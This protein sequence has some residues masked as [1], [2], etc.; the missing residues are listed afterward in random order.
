METSEEKYSRALADLTENYTAFH[1][2]GAAA[3]CPGLEKT[4][5]LSARLGNPHCKYR[6]IHVGGTNGKGS[7]AHTIAAVLQSAGM[8][9]G[10][11][12]S[13]HILDFR[14]RIRVN[15]KMIRKDFVSEF[16]TKLGTIKGEFQPSYFEAVTLMAFD[17]FAAEKIDV[18]VIEVGLGGRLDSTNIITPDLSV[19]TNI[20][21]DHTAILGDTAEAIAAEKAGIIKP[22][23]P[24]VIGAA[25]PSVFE[26]FREKAASCDA[27]IFLASECGIYTSAT[28]HDGFIEYEGTP[29]GLVRGELTGDCQKENAATIMTALQ[30][31]SEAGYPVTAEAVRRGFSEVCGLTGLMGRWMS[32]PGQP[33]SLICDT[34]HNIG[35]W[36][37]LGKQLRRIADAGTLRVLIG[38][39]NDKDADAI[40]ETM[41]RN[42]IYYFTAP[43]VER[44]RA[45][46]STAAIAASHGLS[47]KVFTSV[48]ETYEAVKSEASASDTVFVGGS[49]FIVADLLSI[50][51][52]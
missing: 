14:E 30:K 8:K 22:H 51:G 40:F 17:Y 1:N 36:T 49:T 50:V 37:H 46:E 9:T 31:L 28:E 15:G 11:Y 10:L 5:T 20:S 48:R 44:A 16:M 12:T 19:I 33:F 32:V 29:W 34:G 24:A 4:L 21:L 2:A 6:T 35:G 18:A 23:V 13:P 39:V 3:Y 41:P 25:S 43:G 26:V 45:A 42:A 52:K 7:T 47:G 38:F 27:P